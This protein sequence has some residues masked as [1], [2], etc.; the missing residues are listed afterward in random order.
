MK[1]LK[2]LLCLFVVPLMAACGGSDDGQVTAPTVP[3]TNPMLADP[4]IFEHNGTYY[5]YGTKNNPNIQ[6]Q[7][8]LVYTSTDLENWT[9]SA[10][11]QGGFAFR[12]GDGY[13]TTG[14][15]APQ[16]FEHNGTF[17]M[18]YTANE[19][20]AFAQSDS[21]LG[22]FTNSGNALPGTGNQIDP[23][24]FFE[25]GVPYLYH[26]RLTNGNRIFVAEMEPDFS[27]IKPET[28]TECISATEPWEN[29]ENVGWT[30]TE[31]PTVF[32]QGDLYY[33]LYSANDFRNRDYAVGY[34]TSLSPFGPWEK[35]TGSPFISRNIVGQ[36]GPGHG[37]LFYDTAGNMQYVFHTH[38]NNAQVDPRRTAIV[39]IALQ[40]GV[41]QVAPGAEMHYVL[42]E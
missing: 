7:G 19:K 30:V 39:Q 38:F 18:A 2:K 34:A 14:F 33:M 4:T 23:F 26:V 22:P 28:L 16:V 12:Q 40:G 42:T 27:A 41:V 8:F 32:K 36:P 17:Y 10:G 20:I 9:G 37:D 15:W 5:L 35:N 24:V 31:G 21:P 3:R 25:D 11:A 29:T 13:G 1:Q 6:G